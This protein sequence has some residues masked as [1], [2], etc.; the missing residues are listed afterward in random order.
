MADL[1]VSGKL[2]ISGLPE[3]ADGPSKNRRPRA[4]RTR[5]VGLVHSIAR[6]GLWAP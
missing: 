2:G 1:V 4:M 6:A 5:C 3:D